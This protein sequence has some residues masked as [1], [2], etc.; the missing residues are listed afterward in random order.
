M[1]GSATT[2]RLRADGP[3][4]EFPATDAAIQ[5]GMALT[6]LSTGKVD[7]YTG[8]ALDETHLVMIALEDALQGRNIDQTY[9]TDDPVMC[10]IPRPGDQLQILV[11]TAET[12]V[13]G[14]RLQMEAATGMFVVNATGADEVQFVALE[15]SASGSDRHVA[16]VR[17]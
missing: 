4:F 14:S 17:I 2:I 5:P 1:S 11:D 10:I 12:V 3:H 13:I 7:A 15:A 16:A 6:L 8:A 9:A